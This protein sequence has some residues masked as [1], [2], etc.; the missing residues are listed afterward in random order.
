MGEIN[1][2]KGYFNRFVHAN[3]CQHQLPVSCDKSVLFFL[4]QGVYLSH[5]K[6]YE[7]LLGGKEEVREPFLHLLFLECLQLKIINTLKLHILR[8]HNLIPFSSQPREFPTTYIDIHIHSYE[9]R[10]LH[11]V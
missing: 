1:G 8:C 9:Y 11:G 6:F 2:N 4:A 5:G 10:C 7:L 3:P